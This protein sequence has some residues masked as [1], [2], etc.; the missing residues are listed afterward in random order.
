LPARKVKLIN[1]VEEPKIIYEDPDIL[2]VDKPAG[3]VVNKADTT[4]NILTLQEWAEK[5]IKIEGV[6]DN[7]SEFARRGGVVHRLDK[8][9]SGILVLAKNEKSF[10][11]L[12]A[13]FKNREVKKVY[14]TLCHG[15]VTTKDG[16]IDVPIGRLP[17]N[18]TRFGVL[19]EG[20]QAVTRYKILAI[21]YLA[22]NKS[23]EALSLIEV[24]P[25]TGRTHQIRVHMKYINHPVFADALYAGRK[26][27]RL[28]RKLLQRQFLHASEIMFKHPVT[29]ANLVFKSPLPSDLEEFLGLLLNAE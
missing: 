17:W 29:G 6:T 14:I 20:R 16:E 2:V 5:Y 18:R 26:T 19:S 1:S 13:Q 28:D 9:T 15:V 4:K 24:Y 23:S 12:Q 7:N 21:K 8:E 11:V 27:A 25:Q 22:R 10:T 3:M